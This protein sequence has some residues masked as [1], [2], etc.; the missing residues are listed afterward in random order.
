MTEQTEII[1]LLRG[2]DTKLGRMTCDVASMSEGE[3]KVAMLAAIS[4][5]SLGELVE[6]I[7]SEPTLLELS[8]QKEQTD[9]RYRL[10]AAM[11]VQEQD[12]SFEI[13]AQ[14]A[15]DALRKIERGQ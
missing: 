8:K 13:A 3:Q 7:A 15:R 6:F 1:S 2:I 4:T 11:R 9:K 10:D 12:K 5:S 14:V